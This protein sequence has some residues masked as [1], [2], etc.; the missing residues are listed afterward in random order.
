MKI[1]IA[2]DHGG[3]ELKG[4]VASALAR[5]GHEV[6]DQGVNDPRSV[7]YPDYALR[8][9]RQVASGEAELG[10]LVCGTGIGMS[11]AANKVRGIRAAL[12]GDEFSARMA[13][14]HNDANVLC[15][16]NRVVGI[17]AGVDIV[18]AWLESSFEGDRH[19]RRL[20]RIEE[21]A[22]REGCDPAGRAA[23]G[24]ADPG[25]R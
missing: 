20:D 2:C 24:G 15:L 3:L 13:R 4:A 21:I 25:H 10:V 5:W 9:A 11:I 12:A 17:G 22:E 16:G 14:A 23:A 18:K 19:Q 7:D 1:S 8:V 6:S